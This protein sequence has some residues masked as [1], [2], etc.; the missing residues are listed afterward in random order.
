MFWVTTADSRPDRSRSTS[1]RCPAFGRACQAGCSRRRVRQVGAQ[2]EQPLGA[3]IPGEDA[4]G[5][6]EVG[7]TRLG[8]DPRAGEHGDAGGPDGAYPDRDLL[9][10]SRPR[11]GFGCHAPILSHVFTIMELWSR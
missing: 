9:D 10:L 3:R 4:V 6:A 8:G 11:G 5:S 1:A 2:V 7:D